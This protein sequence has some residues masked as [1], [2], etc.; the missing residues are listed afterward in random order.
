MTTSNKR[1]GHRNA[2]MNHSRVQRAVSSVI[3]DQTRAEELLEQLNATSTTAAAAAATADVV[4]TTATETPVDKQPEPAEKQEAPAASQ[5]H[6]EQ[7]VAHQ[8]A[9]GEENKLLKLLAGTSNDPKTLL[10]FLG[11]TPKELGKSLAQLLTE[12]DAILQA[13]RDRDMCQLLPVLVKVSPFKLPVVKGNLF[14]LIPDVLPLVEVFLK[15]ALSQ[16]MA[17]I[18][19]PS[20]ELL[21]G[22]VIQAAMDAMA[23]LEEIVE[24]LKAE[25]TATSST[26]SDGEVQKPRANVSAPT[27]FDLLIQNGYNQKD[28]ADLAPQITKDETGYFIQRSNGYR[29]YGQWFS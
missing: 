19:M 8:A 18:L 23:E 22:K 15:R 26:P 4:D 2:V 3:A 28:A 10:E 5:S 29:F 14:A 7:E 17:D 11:V 12:Q 13:I 24:E 25:E 1:N 6:D 20:I 9:T 21:F 16:D 27:V